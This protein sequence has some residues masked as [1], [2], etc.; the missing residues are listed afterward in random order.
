[1]QDYNDASNPD[2]NDLA[3]STNCT[4]CHTTSPDW[5]PARFDEHDA[6]FPIYSGTH[7]GEWNT[8]AECHTTSGNYGLFSCIDCHEHNQGD[9]DNEHDEVSGYTYSSLACFECHP[10]GS[11][12]GSFNHNASN[13]PLTG[14]H[15]TTECS[16]CH[17]NGYSGTS[18]VCFACHENDYAQTSNPAIIQLALQLNV[19][20]AIRLILNGNQPYSRTM[21]I[22]IHY[23]ELTP[24]SQ[25]IVSP[26]MREIM[27]IPELLLQLSFGRL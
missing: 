2:H 22:H 17:A 11:G 3:F 27:S 6:L 23:W 21:M 24:K 4:D 15:L 13:F 19:K 7:N 18:T 8:C 5:K 25:I 26:V 16:G 20:P 1:L 9:T 12:E 10:T 14:A